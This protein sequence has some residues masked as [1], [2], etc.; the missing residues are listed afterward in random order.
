MAEPAK[1][2]HLIAIGK[3]LGKSP[4]CLQY[5]S[6]PI[7]IKARG[8]NMHEILYWD[9][10]VKVDQ[11]IKGWLAN[12]PSTWKILGKAPAPCSKPDSAQAASSRLLVYNLAFGPSGAL[13]S[14]HCSKKMHS[15]TGSGF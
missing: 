9:A 3:M 14:W 2:R 15:T 10:T 5:Q 1:I 6:V 8:S 11:N 12:L 4:K 7:L 13:S